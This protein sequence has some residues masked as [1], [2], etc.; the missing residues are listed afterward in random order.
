MTT[1]M[2]WTSAFAQRLGVAAPSDEDVQTI[3][4]LAGCAAHAS[5]R[6]AAPV[7]CWMA[8]RSDLTLSEAL[9]LAKA[10]SNADDASDQ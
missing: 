6:T 8:A 5:E 4:A 7:A 1:S 3:L 2:E 10:L 9:E